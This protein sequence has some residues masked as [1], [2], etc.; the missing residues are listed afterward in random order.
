MHRQ[1]ADHLMYQI[2]FYRHR[3]GATRQLGHIANKRVQLTTGEHMRILIANG[4][5]KI[6]R[7]AAYSHTQCCV[8]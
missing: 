2:L 5:A 3:Y 8:Q 1:N 4:Q 7:S 6:E